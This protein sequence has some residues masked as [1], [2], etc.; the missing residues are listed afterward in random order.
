[1]L[2][3]DILKSKWAKSLQEVGDH[4]SLPTLTSCLC[5]KLC[6]PA[7]VTKAETGLWICAA[8]A[9]EHKAC[10]FAPDVFLTS[11]FP[12]LNY[13]SI[14][15]DTGLSSRCHPGSD[16][17]VPPPCSHTRDTGKVSSC[18]VTFLS[19]RPSS[20]SFQLHYTVLLSLESSV[21]DRAVCPPSLCYFRE[22][23][24]LESADNTSCCVL[25]PHSP[26]SEL[27]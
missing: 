8:P 1:M 22:T 13:N 6:S 11:T 7:P 27:P 21:T 10:M 20:V 26:D 23:G 5:Q 19:H 17:R 9:P 12:P 3:L 14:V 18:R 2:V 4:D 24:C 15:E 16:T 25:A